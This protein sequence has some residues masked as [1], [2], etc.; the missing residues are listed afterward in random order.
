[1]DQLRS[2]LE[3]KKD[4]QIA[5]KQLSLLGIGGFISS[6][7]RGIVVLFSWYLMKESPNYMWVDN[8]FLMPLNNWIAFFLFIKMI[9]NLIPTVML[10]YV[11]YFVPNQSGKI[12]KLEIRNKDIKLSS[13]DSITSENDA[14]IA[15]IKKYTEDEGFL[16]NQ[17]E[18]NKSPTLMDRKSY[19]K[20][21]ISNDLE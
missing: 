14:D 13:S 15:N 6:I 19:N 10:F 2:L 18:R 1:M 20:F 5:R 11:I 8:M 7:I 21:K 3:Q 16:Y 9:S 12:K 4:I 17:V